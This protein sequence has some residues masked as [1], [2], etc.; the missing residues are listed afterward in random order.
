VL[1]WYDFLCPFCYV[2]QH[3]TAILTRRR[4]TDLRAKPVPRERLHLVRN[5]IKPV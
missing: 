3:R 4:H 2:G 1:H 5:V